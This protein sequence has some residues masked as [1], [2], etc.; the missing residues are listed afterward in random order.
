VDHLYGGL[1]ADIHY[2]DANDGGEIDYARYDD[3]NYGNLTIRLDVSTLNTSAA[4]GDS[5]VNIEGLVGGAGNDTVVGNGLANYLFGASGDDFIY[6]Q[7]GADYLNGGAG[8]DSLWGRAGA[9]QHIGGDGAE[10]DFARYDD[11]NW[12]NL[13]LRL[14]NAHSMS[15]LPPWATLM[16]ASRA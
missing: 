1:G 9:D 15:A 5:Y 11:A 2:G 8:A 10:L 6:G 13:T 14:D 4:A 12:G 3:A 16:S 7:G